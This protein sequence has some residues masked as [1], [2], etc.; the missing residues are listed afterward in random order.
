MLALDTQIPFL[1]PN[2]PTFASFNWKYVTSSRNGSLYARSYRLFFDLLYVAYESVLSDMIHILQPYMGSS[3]LR[4]I[5]IRTFD[6]KQSSLMSHPGLM[7]HLPKSSQAIFYD[8]TFIVNTLAASSLE[9]DECPN[10]LRTKLRKAIR[11][12]FCAR[13][14]F[15]PTSADLSEFL[16]HYR[17]F[18]SERNLQC[19][20]RKSIALLSAASNLALVEVRGPDQRLACSSLLA[21]EKPNALFLYGLTLQSDNYGS[22]HLMH[23]EAMKSMAHNDFKYYDLCGYPIGDAGKGLFRFKSSL[24]GD[25][26]SF[27]PE[28][29]YYTRYGSAL[30]MAARVKNNPLSF[31]S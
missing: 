7:L 29:H 4:R 2:W 3:L 10:P 8:H 1:N 19:P 15:S 24:L 5:V 20:S 12:G 28:L 16:K 31:L 21:L 14:S 25:H 26:Y 6:Q 27:G 30:K 13:F 11:H 9:V 22:N 17:I 23:Y 18:S